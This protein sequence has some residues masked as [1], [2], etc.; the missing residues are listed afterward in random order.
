MLHVAALPAPKGDRDFRQGDE[1]WFELSRK[2]AATGKLGPFFSH[3]FPG[4]SVFVC[5]RLKG[6]YFRPP[7]D[8]IIG[9]GLEA[10]GLRWKEVLSKLFSRAN[11][12]EV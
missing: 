10:S 2:D 12:S 4:V 7:C 3:L 5:R 9:S 8:E 6:R 1:G 11:Q